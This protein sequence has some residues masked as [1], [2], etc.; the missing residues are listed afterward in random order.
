LNVVLGIS[1]GIAA[2]KAPDLVRR[3]RER[4]AEVQIIMTASAEEFVTSTALQAVSGKPVRSNLWDK[5]AEAAMSHIELAR[6][7]DV[8]VIA[9]A[10]AEVMARIVSGG[11]P[12]LLTTVCLATEA[13]IALAPAMNHVMW[14][15][16][17]TKANRE[18]LEK[19]GIHILG[20]G[21][22]SQ[23][24]GETGAGRM[25]E[26]DAIAAAVFSLTGGKGEGL[27]EGK[28][29]VITAGPTREA[30][31]PVRYITNRSS[32][33]MGYAMAS[34]AAAQGASVVLIS[35]PVN[36]SPPPGVDVVDVES[37]EQM[38]AATHAVIGDADIFVGA[39]A[40]ADYRP[41]SV[42]DQKIKK[43]DDAMRLE[44]VRCPDI[45]ASVAGLDAPPFTVGFAAETE[46]VI[47]YARGKLENK[48]LDLIIANRVGDNCG[49]DRDDNTATAL[50]KNGEKSF[51][52]CS[53]ID[54]ARELIELVA[55]H[56]YAVRGADTQP[57]LTIISNSD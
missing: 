9:P 16:P 47:D 56:F 19:R 49:F 38:Y 57:K 42:V 3:L 1:G 21:I 14:S 7:A 6:W 40:V 48:K 4:G 36:L 17:A 26:P 34:A 35:G 55:E 12:D 15:N 53:K 39:A 52:T 8:V 37:A 10:T 31:D 51:P 33:K 18:V 13:P 2:Y 22:G 43:K 44:L 25:L 24:C 28:K 32:G 5:E 27:L 30:I 54:L 41:A 50:W 29:V 45:L 23:A 46:N 20:P 11:A